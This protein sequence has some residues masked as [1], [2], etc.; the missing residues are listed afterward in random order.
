MF[1]WMSKLKAFWQDDY[2]HASGVMTV[3]WLLCWLILVVVFL[4]ETT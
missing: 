3:F 4:S 1:D 2:Y